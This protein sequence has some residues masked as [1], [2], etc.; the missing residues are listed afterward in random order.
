MPPRYGTRPFVPVASIATI[1]VS[2]LARSSESHGQRSASLEGVQEIETQGSKPANSLDSPIVRAVRDNPSGGYP[3]GGEFPAVRRARTIFLALAI[4]ASAPLTAATQ[5]AFTL[6]RIELVFTNGRGDIT[7]PLRYP[8]L[9]VFGLLRFAGLGVLH[10]TWKVDGR[11]IATVAEPTLFGEDVILVTPDLP[12]LEPGLHRVTLEMIEPKPAF[13]I[14][15]IT[16]F[17]TAEDYQDFKK[18]TERPR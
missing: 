5:T 8:E 10:G 7:V 15:T 3:R 6:T 1:G 18:R 13:K 17:V 14:P 4:A 2:G 11:L 12:T 9:R 16:Y